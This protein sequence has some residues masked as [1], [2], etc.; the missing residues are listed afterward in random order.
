MFP[1]T[2]LQHLPWL[3]RR[4]KMPRFQISLHILGPNIQVDG[5]GWW[6]GMGWHGWE[7]L[8]LVGMGWDGLRWVEGLMGWDGSK[9]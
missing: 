7:G 4:S 6:V 1:T 9:G 3:P 8:G 5:R 2:G